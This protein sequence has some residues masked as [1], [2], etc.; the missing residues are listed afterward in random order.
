[1]RRRDPIR[2]QPPVA[3]H[4][5]DI[6]REKHSAPRHPLPLKSVAMKVN[7]PGQQQSFTQIPHRPFRLVHDVRDPARLHPDYTKTNRSIF[8]QDPGAS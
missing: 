1:M 5:R 4:Q 3:I 2:Q 8:P 6:Q 7:H